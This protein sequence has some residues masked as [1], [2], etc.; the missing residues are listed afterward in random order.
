MVGSLQ[1]ALPRALGCDVLVARRTTAWIVCGRWRACAPL[2]LL[3]ATARH[4]LE[5]GG[6]QQD[7]R[8]AANRQNIPF[9][10][11][12]VIWQPT[13]RSRHRLQLY[14]SHS[15]TARHHFTA[16][17]RS[18]RVEKQASR[19]DTHQTSHLSS[20]RFARA[21]RAGQSPS[22]ETAVQGERHPR[23]GS[24]ARGRGPLSPIAQAAHAR[25]AR[26]DAGCA[27]A[28]ATRRVFPPAAIARRI[29]SLQG[30]ANHHT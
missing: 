2:L 6:G 11:L 25:S 28:A 7:Q 18:A 30:A 20:R 22:P 26:I 3:L 23:A 14:L 15:S 12:L 16:H 5:R 13:G 9:T 4:P 10:P 24:P 27:A 29:A 17:P 1:S 19:F 21:R 8:C